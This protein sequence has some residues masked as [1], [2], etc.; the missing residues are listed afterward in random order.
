MS[1]ISD[2]LSHVVFTHIPKTAGTTLRKILDKQ[3]GRRRIFSIYRPK[4]EAVERLLRLPQSQRDQYR[5]ITGHWPF[6]L[7][8]HFSGK[9]CY[10]SMMRDPVKRLISEYY[11]ILSLPSHY[12]Y[13]AVTEG[14]M[15]LEN[16]VLSDLAPDIDNGQLR[17]LA[18]F[19][20]EVPCGSIRDEHLE[21][22]KQNIEKYYPVVGLTE[23]FDESILLF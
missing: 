18:G 19:E 4:P 8:E 20:G 14:G 13:S 9:S 11:Y 23:R 15:S 17:L 1:N 2:P 22:A 7:H 5:L 3:Y 6:G 16:Y 21:Q 10:I 12:L